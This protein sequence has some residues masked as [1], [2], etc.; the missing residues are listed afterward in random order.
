MARGKQAAVGDERV[1]QNGYRYVKTPQGWRLK[2]QI[3]LEEK[4]GRPLAENER[5]R[6]E[7]QDRTNLDPDN[8]SV[9]LVAQQSKG[10]RRAY[11]EMKIEEL[12]SELDRLNEEES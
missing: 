11:L 7:D 3:I 6:F 8:L 12:Q 4:L 5:C 1:S 10:K 9:Y 2:H